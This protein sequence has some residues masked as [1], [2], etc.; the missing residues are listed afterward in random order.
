MT[1][2][3]ESFYLDRCCNLI[4]QK[5]A[6]GSSDAWTNRDFEKLSEDIL[7]TCGV[8]LSTSTL[9][10]IWGKVKY[11]S[12]PALNTLNTLAQYLGK[13]NWRVFK[14]SEN[15]ALAE[16]VQPIEDAFAFTPQTSIKVKR[17]KIPPGLI[18]VL[19]GMFFLIGISG[20]VFFQIKNSANDDKNIDY[21]FNSRKVASGIPNSVVFEYDASKAPSDS[22]F[23]Q[24]SWDISRRTLVNKEKTRHTSIYY[25]PGFY[26]AKLVIDDK[27]VREHE[28]LIP[29]NGWIAAIEQEPV[30]VY[31]DQKEF[32]KD[33]EIDVS[34]KDIL[35]H[36]IAMEPKTPIVNISQ[37]GVMDS[38]TNDNFTFETTIKNTYSNGSAVCQ[39][40]DIIILCKNDVFIIPL[41]AK[42]CTGDLKLYI[43]GESISSTQADLSKFGCDLLQWTK[44]K[45]VSKNR[46]VSI[47]VNGE[48]A[49]VVQSHNQPAE[50]IG[51]R[52]R[53]VGTGAVKNTRFSNAK[54]TYTF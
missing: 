27:V 7:D 48:P 35:S 40:S 22:I 41:V 49:Y 30:P 47:F 17:D 10:R 11:E 42:G 3:E 37:V 38:L 26:K 36:G 53:F 24:Q 34:E 39:R 9:K 50:I 1:I 21:K 18:K 43:A 20:F 16:C 23:I 8:H 44:I 13:E 28:L 33:D 46:Q 15:I 4:E 6:W 25:Y 2:K 29:C 31:L 14:Q 45:V 54:T 32:L 19:L 5:L 12:T 51:V 52:F